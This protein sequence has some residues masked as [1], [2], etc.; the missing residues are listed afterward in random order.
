MRINEELR[1]EYPWR[2]TWDKRN[3]VVAKAIPE[4]VSV[5]DLGGGFGNLYLHLK[6]CAHYI[7]IDIKEWTDLTIKADF[8]KGEFPDFCPK[9]EFQI[10]VCQGLIEYIEKSEEFLEAIKK[11]G[12]KLLI[13]RDNKMGMDDFKEL[14]KKTGW[15]IVFSRQAPGSQ[16]LFYC[17]KK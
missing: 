4:G 6:N 3:E 9:R 10:I 8:N 12:S 11:Y 2:K 13:T 1:K 17:S 5:L 15:E 14:L 16:K 7:S